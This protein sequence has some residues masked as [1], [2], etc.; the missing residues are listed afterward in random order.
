MAALAVICFASGQ[1]AHAQQAKT[2]G[3]PLDTIMSTK[4]WADVPEAKDFVRETRKPADSLDYQP[5]TG[6]DPE[7]PKLRDKAELKSLQDELERAVAG[8]DDTARK[9]LGIKKPAAKPVIRHD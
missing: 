9:R 6:T 5:V 4:L 8:N 7:R 1:P 2:G 3:S